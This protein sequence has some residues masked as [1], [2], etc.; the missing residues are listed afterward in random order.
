MIRSIFILFVLTCSTG[1]F[2]QVNKQIKE[3]AKKQTTYALELCKYLH[4]NPELSF[5]EFETSARMAKELKEIGFE[6]TEKFAG[7]SVVGIYKNG[8]GPTVFLRTDMDALP[9][10]ENT[11][12]PFA[13]KKMADLDGNQ[14]SVMHACGHDIHMSTWTGTLRTLVALKNEWKGTLVVI[15]Q[16]AEEYSGGAGEAINAGL[17]SK[18]PTPDYALA[19]HINPEL[20]TGT[21]GLRGGPVFAGVKTVEITVYGKGGHGA[22]PQKCIDPIVISSRIVNDLQTIVSRELS[23]T[24]PAVVTVGS[25]HGGTRPN[26][27]PDEVKM[28]LTLRYFSD[29]TIQKVIAS[30]KRISENAARVA[31]VPEDKLPFV[32][33]FD[34]ET[35]PVLN[36]DALSAEV[37]GFAADIIGRENIIETQPEMVGEDFGKYGRTEEDIPICLIWLGSTSP[38]EMQ[39][40]KAEGKAPY[41]LHSPQLNPDYENTIKT[42]IEVMTGNVI[43]LM[44]K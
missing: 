22:Y 13:S 44:E 28:Q 23:P 43:G 42:G 41:P 27:I 24:E 15:A 7:N 2:A 36:D 26:I 40:L 14:V 25:I 11:D 37:S 30:I 3:E 18:F 9:V 20:E 21:I 1:V 16:Q 19:Y 8:D 39:R 32:D 38:E 4:E 33:V 17:F 5:Q 31:G 12:F 6:V 10:E 34:V 35:P 29:E